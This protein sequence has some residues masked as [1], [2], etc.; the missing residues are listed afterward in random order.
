M[1]YFI[2]IISEKYYDWNI[3]VPVEIDKSLKRD[4]IPDSFPKYVHCDR[5][6][7]CCGNTWFQSEIKLDLDDV[8]FFSSSSSIISYSFEHMV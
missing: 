7:E 6:Y 5:G 8:M 4:E 3:K 1:V 2:N